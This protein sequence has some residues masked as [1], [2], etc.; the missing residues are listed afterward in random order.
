MRNLSRLFWA[1][2]L[3]VPS[4]SFAKE[5]PKVA[6]WDLVPRNISADYASQLTSILVS[7]TTKLK[8][9][10]VYSQENVRTIAGWTEQKMSLGC[11]DTKCLTALGQ[12]DIS[13][14]I[15]GSVGKIGSRYTISLSLF[16]TE[17][18]LTENA[19]SEFCQTEDELIELIQVSVRKLLGEP[20]EALTLKPFPTAKA[21]KESEVIVVRATEFLRGLNV[22]LGGPLNTDWGSDVL[23]NAPDYRY[24]PNAAEFEFKAKKGGTYRLKA[25][26]AAAEARPVRI[27]LNGSLAIS[28]AL[29][30][31]TGCWEQRCQTLLYQ[32]QVVL[33]PGWN[34]MR[35]ERDNV[36]P[37]IRRFVFESL[38]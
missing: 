6:V 33:K 37:H 25:E 23:L 2:L 20:L 15:S 30:S 7:E 1:Y 32:G 31:P 21:E 29:N 9:Y 12:M 5:L 24:R 13:K 19:L 22:A 18:T 27:L 16:D 26:Y 4:F 36:F 11:T 38:N 35:V 17:N 28:N 3:I 34:V 10:R 8:K 14:L